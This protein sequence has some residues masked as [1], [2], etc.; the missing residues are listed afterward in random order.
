MRTSVV[1][2]VHVGVSA[3]AVFHRPWTCDV[4]FCVVVVVV[5]VLFVLIVIVVLVVSVVVFLD[6]VVVVAILNAKLTTR[7]TA[8]VINFFDPNF[9]IS[10]KSRGD[11]WMWILCN[12]C[13]LGAL[14]S[15]I[16]GALFAAGRSFVLLWNVWN[17]FSTYAFIAIVEE[18]GIWMVM[19]GPFWLIVAG[20]RWWMWS[21]LLE[22]CANSNLKS[23]VCYCNF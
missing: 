1:V 11:W 13:C 20:G 12:V 21:V 23:T 5:V 17:P 14:L 2:V 19:G 15:T 9:G 10:A 4:C 16:R 22:M 8:A 18:S 7:S 6:V 3:F